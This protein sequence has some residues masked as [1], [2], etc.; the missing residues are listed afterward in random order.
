[1]RSTIGAIEDN[2][3]DWIANRKG[4][5]EKTTDCQYEMEV[6]IKEIEPNSGE[7]DFHG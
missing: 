6:S 3:N 5:R 7:N 2:M 1:M 4:D